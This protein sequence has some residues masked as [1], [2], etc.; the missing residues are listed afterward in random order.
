VQVVAIDPSAAFRKA[1]REELPRV[2]VSVDH[3]H[4]VQL[5]NDMVTVVRQRLSQQ[6]KGRRGR[7]V[8]PSWAHRQL[9]LRA[10]DSLSVAGLAR[11]KA[12][13]RS[14]DPTDELGAAWGVKEQLRRLLGAS[15]LAGARTE[16]VR[17]G[18]FVLAAKMPE[19]DRLWATVCAW[20][21]AI[22]V[23]VVTGVTNAKTEAANH[24]QAP[25]S[26]RQRLPQRTAL[27]G[28]D[29]AGQRRPRTR[30]PTM[31][32][33]ADLGLGCP[34][35]W[36]PFA[37]RRGLSGS[38]VASFGCAC[39]A[40]SAPW[41]QVSVWRSCSGSVAIFAAV[42]PRTASAPFPASGGPFLVRSMVPFESVLRY[43]DHND[44]AVTRSRGGWPRVDL[45]T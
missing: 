30:S 10:G 24:D 35:P 12:T 39:W 6:T 5:A 28:P 37:C 27:P 26:L 21:P 9:L 38:L 7:T 20:W 34:G 17:L 15:S 41:S 29:P 22:A 40:I 16:K 11:L 43:A 19:T 23:L 1:I 4:L 18:V 45:S 44:S 32:G 14:D 33:M 31:T 36:W 3:F 42:A 2:A 13:F 25:Q 8:D